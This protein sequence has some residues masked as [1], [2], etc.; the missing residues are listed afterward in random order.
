MKKTSLKLISV[1]FVLSMFF[2]FNGH[3][4]AML[5]EGTDPTTK[6]TEAKIVDD[7]GVELEA[8]E[9]VDTKA[10]TST[11]SDFTGAKSISLDQKVS[12]DAVEFGDSIFYKV[13]TVNPGYQLSIVGNAFSET[14]NSDEMNYLAFTLYD[15]LGNMLS[16]GQNLAD[17]KQEIS[18]FYYPGQEISTTVGKMV[19][20]KVS[21]TSELKEK[22]SSYSFI[23]SLKDLTD[24]GSRKDAGES[25][26][27]GPIAISKGSYNQNYI[28]INKCG[29]NKYCSTD[30]ADTFKFSAFANSKVIFTIKPASTLGLKI[31]VMDATGYVIS[32]KASI[33]EGREF[34][35]E[36]TSYEDRDLYF[37]ISPIASSKI[38][39]GLYEFSLNVEE[40]EPIT[41]TEDERGDDSALGNMLSN[42]FIIYL[43]IAVV[44]VIVVMII[45]FRVSKRSGGSVNKKSQ[46]GADIVRRALREKKGVVMKDPSIVG[47]E[48][49]LKNDL[50]SFKSQGQKTPEDSGATQDQVSSDVPRGYIS[51]GSM[52]LS[53]G[54]T[55][56]RPK[57]S[58]GL[59]T[60]STD[61][62][63]D[64]D[65]ED[66]DI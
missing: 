29:T 58:L 55:K 42:K 19:Y 3:A 63:K 64:I 11:P 17:G 57:S 21:V 7:K 31:M 38:K 54:L 62:N 14:G 59:E 66:I 41:G 9:N 1:I 16:Q 34:T 37:N 32:E 47:N 6:D 61:K 8:D 52:D 49:S 50:Y 65:P 22:V 24:A 30:N 27:S 46:Q 26:S 12:G 48:K 51:K 60:Y 5:V 39:F 40:V 10:S 35:I 44:V 53:G 36:V 13:T 28:G 18:T 25:I 4:L 23:A 33:S 43:G 2:A 15:E 45:F 20:M 56:Q